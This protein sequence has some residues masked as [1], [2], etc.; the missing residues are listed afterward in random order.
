[1][2]RVLITG[3]N[4]Y[5]GRSFMTYV[6]NDNQLE[7]TELD[8]RD[9]S[10][11][12]Y[13]FSVY[14]AI[15]HVAGIAHFSKDSSQ[16]ELYYQVNTDLTRDIAQKAKTDGVKQFIFMSSI[17]V[18][19]DSTAAERVIT[20][21]T[22]PNPSDFYGDSKLKAEQALQELADEQFKIAIIRPPMIYGKGSKGNYPRLATLA[23][24]ILIFPQIANQRSMLYIDNLCE[25]LKQLMLQDLQGIFFPQ[26]RDYVCTSKLICTIAEIHGK[27]IKTTS[28]FNPFVYLFFKFDTIKKLF[29]NL[30]YEK[31]MSQYH[32]EYQIKGFEE[33]IR[34]TEESVR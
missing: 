24:K 5:I 15:F 28:L 14:D 11:K 7:V 13:D 34:V 25:F 20:R 21:D 16:K 32:F 17:I 8:V 22:Q 31:G 4:S 6:V 1:M 33:S 29:G 23:Q 10:W 3:A 27:T 9:A 2:K 18:Y 30:V 26:N 12:T 19:G